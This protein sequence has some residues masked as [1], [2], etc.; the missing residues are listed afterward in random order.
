MKTR[1]LF[2]YGSLKRGF[3]NH[4]ILGNSLFQC[5]GETI[6]LLVMLDLGSFPACILPTQEDLPHLTSIKGEV[7]IVDDDTFDRVEHLEG[8]PSFYDR[9]EIPIKLN[10]NTDLESIEDI[11]IYFLRD[12]YKR[13]E[14]PIV[15]NGEWNEDW[16][17]HGVY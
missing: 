5:K 17:A 12:N 8:Y 15:P 13:R 2:V 3:G 7:Y 9:M 6:D 16:R 14:Q 10:P 4:S 11:P 1:K